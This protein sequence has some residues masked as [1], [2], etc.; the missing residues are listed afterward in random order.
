[1]RQE[2]TVQASIFD[3]FAGHEIGRRLKAMSRWL[4]ERCELLGMVAADLC[5]Q[6]V[7]ETGRH[8]LPAERAALCGA[9]ATPTAELSGAGVPSG[10]LGVISGVCR[11]P[12]SWSPRKSVLHKTI[13]AIQAETW[14]AINRALLSSAAEAR[15]SA[16]G[17]C[18]ST[19]RSPRR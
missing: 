10:G 18:A 14:E 15:W 17:W 9:Q 19:A 4:D 16:A 1:M 2:R 8:G 6:G 13:S 5:R 3:L 7:K 12:W 11:L